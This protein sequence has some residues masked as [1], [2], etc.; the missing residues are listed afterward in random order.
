MR[1]LRDEAENVNVVNGYVTLDVFPI[2]GKALEQLQA[3]G[4]IP[5]EV[6]LPDLSQPVEP[7]PLASGSGPPSASRCPTTSGPSS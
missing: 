5:P 4:I 3:S 2:V 6:V 7:G 1:L